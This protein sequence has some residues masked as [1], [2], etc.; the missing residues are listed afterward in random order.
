MVIAPAKTGKDKTSKK[1]V[2]KIDQTNK[3]ILCSV[4]SGVLILNIVVIKFIA[5][6]IDDAPAKCKL[7]IAKSIAGPG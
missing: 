7:S 4:I 1:T 5:P 6:N 3:G 2:T